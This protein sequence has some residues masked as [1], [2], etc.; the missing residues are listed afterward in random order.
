MGLQRENLAAAH[1]FV[2][3]A[4]W[5]D[6]KRVA[7]TVG[8]ADAALVTDAP[9]VAAAKAHQRAGFEAAIYCIERAHTFQVDAAATVADKVSPAVAKQP[10][11]PNYAS[12][13]AAGQSDFDQIEAKIAEEGPLGP[14]LLAQMRP[15]SQD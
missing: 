8:K 9:E 12:P 11:T 7:E 2:N 6:M 15:M 3:S 1:Q 4:L 13:N 5:W 14:T 10:P